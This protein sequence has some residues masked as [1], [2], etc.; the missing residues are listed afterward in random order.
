MNAFFI[1]CSDKNDNLNEKNGTIWKGVSFDGMQ[2][3]DTHDP[4][5]N[6]TLVIDYDNNVEV[7]L[8]TIGIGEKIVAI[9]ILNDFK[10]AITWQ[11]NNQT[12]VVNTS[13][14]FNDQ[15]ELTIDRFTFTVAAIPFPSNL[16]PAKFMKEPN[17]NN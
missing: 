8:P 10:M 6:Y 9:E 13:Y 16:V 4:E 11:I 12:K 1:G 2:N 15:N 14:T 7:I 3:K 17:S 5:Y